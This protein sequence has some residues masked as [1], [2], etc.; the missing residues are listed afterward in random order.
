MLRRVT[1]M[2]SVRDVFVYALVKLMYEAFDQEPPPI[3]TVISGIKD[4]QS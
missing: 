2:A 4:R 1:T 3:T